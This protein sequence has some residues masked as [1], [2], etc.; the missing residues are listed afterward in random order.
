MLLHDDAYL[1]F[2]QLGEVVA[3]CMPHNVACAVI[4]CLEKACDLHLPALKTV[5]VASCFS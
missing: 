3:D 2:A 5:Q 1:N 4:P